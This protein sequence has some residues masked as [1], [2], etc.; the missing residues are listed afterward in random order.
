MSTLNPTEDIY[1]TGPRYY[2]P[3]RK[4]SNQDVI[5]WMGASFRPTWISHRTGVEYRHWATSEQACSDLAAICAN[6]LMAHHDIDRK[7]IDQ[8]LLSTISGDHPT[9]PTS[10]LLLPKIGFNDIGVIDIGAACAGFTTGLF[11]AACHLLATRKNK[12]LIS[13]EIRSKFLAKKDLATTALFGD[14]SA[15][16]LISLKKTRAD[17]KLL[18]AR[19]GADPSVADIISIPAGGSKLPF[20]EDSEQRGFLHMQ[21]GA[22]LFVKGVNI[23]SQ[24]AVSFLDTFQMDINDIDWLVPHQ[25]NR[26]L[27]NAVAERVGLP[28]EKLV[29]TVEHTGNTSGASVGIALAHLL[30]RTELKHGDKILLVSAGAGGS[31]A[32]ALLE[33]IEH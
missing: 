5:D 9:P 12:L 29:S 8:L 6:D 1:I 18:G 16:C 20:H 28:N 30:E 15:S 24:S 32:C 3:P 22:T 25:A 23:M 4:M 21:K 13:S 33:R 11:T 2:L 17:F 14:G 31:A 19:L 27:M 10:P 26:L 7:D